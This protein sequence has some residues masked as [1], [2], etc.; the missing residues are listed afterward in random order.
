MND[1]RDI[2]TTFKRFKVITTD[3]FVV[4][5]SQAEYVGDDGE[6]SHVASCDIYEFIDGRIAAI[7]SY[8]VEVPPGPSGS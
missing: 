2:E 1:L 7:T 3:D 6:S 4:I 5:D 8:N